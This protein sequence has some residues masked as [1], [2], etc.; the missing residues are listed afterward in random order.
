MCDNQVNIY[1]N[2]LILVEALL[3]SE[4][5]PKLLFSVMNILILLMNSLT[6]VTS[7]WTHC[8]TALK[9]YNK[10]VLKKKKKKLK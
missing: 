10:S 9:C 4:V 7:E 3:V 5:S 8:R 6:F 1:A 2:C